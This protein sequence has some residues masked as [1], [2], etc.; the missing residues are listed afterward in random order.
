M[1]KKILIVVAHPDDETF[2][3]AGTIAKHIRERDKV[4]AISFTD[5]V[6]SRNKGG[7]AYKGRIA[8]L[9]KAEKI[10]GFKWIKNLNFENNKLDKVG[11]LKLAKEIENK[12]KLNLILFTSQLF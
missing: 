8:S 7:L 2:G 11:L 5:G 12:K 1:K 4:L 6:S 3:M 10:L 9:K